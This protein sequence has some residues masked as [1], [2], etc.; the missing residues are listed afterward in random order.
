MPPIKLV[1]STVKAIRAAYERKAKNRDSVGI[2]VSQAGEE[3]E[4]KLW[5]ALHWASPREAIDGRKL[6]LFGT[7]N[8]EED[9]ML[10]DLE[11]AGFEV[12]R[13]DP[14]TGGQ[15]RVELVDGWLR[16]YTDGKIIGLYH[17]PTLPHVLELKTHNDRSFKDLVKRGIFE[18]KPSHYVQMQ[19][20]MHAQGLEAC[21]YLA[22]N[23]NDEYMFEDIVRYNKKFCEKIEAKVARIVK[24]K[25]APPKLYEDPDA[26][27]AFSCTWC[28][29]LAQCHRG[30]LAR[31]NCRTCISS[32][33]LPG[34]VVRCELHEKELTIEEQAVGCDKHVYIPDLVPGEQIDADADERSVTYKMQDGTEWKNK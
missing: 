10:D 11:A 14:A 12:V 33:F 4:R 30:V 3:C 6:R 19:M 17:A 9:R 8:V 23:K 26:K 24:A 34:A 28:P 27:M 22:L 20:Y 7:G 18:S 25:A 5:Y 13:R 29:A 31:K 21:L 15:F 2:N 16:G 32:T 1:S